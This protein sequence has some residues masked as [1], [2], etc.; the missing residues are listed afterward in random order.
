[1]HNLLDQ[2]FN[3]QFQDEIQGASAALKG[4]EESKEANTAQEYSL[5]QSQ[6]SHM[7][8][9]LLQLTQEKKK[10]KK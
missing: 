3:L 4:K 2:I 6:A 9:Y 1:M 8:E 10:P 5:F 7:H